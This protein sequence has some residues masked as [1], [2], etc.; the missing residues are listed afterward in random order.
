MAIVVATVPTDPI[1]TLGENC[2]GSGFVRLNWTVYAFHA[3]RDAF[4]RTER[5]I[6]PVD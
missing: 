6:V 2:E 5:D 1:E 3:G 4:G